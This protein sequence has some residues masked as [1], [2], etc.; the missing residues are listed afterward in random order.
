LDWIVAF[1]ILNN[2][3]SGISVLV[4]H[5]FFY[6]WNVLNQKIIDWKQIVQR[7]LSYSVHALI[8]VVLLIVSFKILSG[9]FIDFS[10]FI[11]M[12]RVAGKS[13]PSLPYPDNMWMLSI[14]FYGYNLVRSFRRSSEEPL[15][16]YR[17]AVSIW[18]ITGFVYFV[19]RSHPWNL[20]NISLPFFIAYGIFI[21]SIYAERFQKNKTFSRMSLRVFAK[22]LLPNWRTFLPF[23][24]FSIYAAPFISL[25]TIAYLQFIPLSISNFST[26]KNYQK[27]A[28]IEAL[29]NQVARLEAKL[30]R[31][32]IILSESFE[33]YY[34]FLKK[35]PVLYYPDM[36]SIQ[37]MDS[38]FQPRFS[39]TLQTYNPIVVSCSFQP[40]FQKI[41]QRILADN[42]YQALPLEKE[43]KIGDRDS[44]QILI[45]DGKIP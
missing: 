6:H 21:E 40:E 8:I 44:C 12:Y 41:F 2:I 24:L 38:S 34:Y 17:F 29:S 43:I 27:I 14:V 36:V 31:P 15:D 37:F 45:R 26:P 10:L 25:A 7:F 23:T 3:D 4:I 30:N 22:N 42:N 11:A 32:S 20:L 18:G 33:S 16:K 13:S 35:R 1:A 39:S 5:F 9:K 28:D 19:N